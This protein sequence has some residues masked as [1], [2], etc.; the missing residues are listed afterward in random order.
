MNCFFFH[1][2]KILNEKYGGKRSSDNNFR[3]FLSHSSLDKTLIDKIF[4]E[5]QKS[6]INVW[7]DKYEI[8]YGDSIT[9][10]INEG[11]YNCGLGLICVSQNFLRSN[12][13]KREMNYYLQKQI[14]SGENNL[15]CINMDVSHNNLPPLIQDYRYLDFNNTNWIDELVAVIK[16]KA[17]HNN[18]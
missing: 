16:K 12:W 8:E 1:S 6:E 11:L 5:L 10:K 13:A 17:V 14:S 7:Y 3:I 15:I 2:K 9:D 4:L 18:I